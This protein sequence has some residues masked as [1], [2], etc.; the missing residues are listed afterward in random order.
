MKTKPFYDFQINVPLCLQK[1]KEGD[2][3]AFWN[4]A[5]LLLYKFGTSFNV[6][7]LW[8]FQ[9]DVE[10]SLNSAFCTKCIDKLIWK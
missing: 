8:F 7:N 4:T 10:V 1:N 2:A 9:F 6:W 3:I 5:M